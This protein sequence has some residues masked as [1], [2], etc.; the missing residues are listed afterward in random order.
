MISLIT[1]THPNFAK[2]SVQLSQDLDLSTG[3]GDHSLAASVTLCL[4]DQLHSKRKKPQNSLITTN[5]KVG[6]ERPFFH[7]FFL[8]IYCLVVCLEHDFYNNNSPWQ[9][10]AAHRHKVKTGCGRVTCHRIVK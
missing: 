3:Q 2:F 1:Y 4:C 5:E 8:S 10:L 6:K 7:F 9:A